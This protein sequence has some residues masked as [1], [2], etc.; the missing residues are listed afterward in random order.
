MCGVLLLRITLMIIVAWSLLLP[1]YLRDANVRGSAIAQTSEEDQPSLDEEHVE[2][3]GGQALT[4]SPE[5]LPTTNETTTGPTT[6]GPTT[7]GPTT[8]GPTTTGPTTTGPTTTG[9]TNETTNEPII[10]KPLITNNSALEGKGEYQDALAYYDRALAMDP[11]NVSAL[12]GKGA[13]L[14]NLGEYQDALAYYDRALAMD[15]SNVN[16]TS[17]KG[18]ALGNLGRYEEAIGYIDRALAMDPS[19]VNTINNKGAALFYLGREEEAIVNFDRVLA[20]DPSNVDALTNKG[21]TLAGLGRY[22][23]AIG[24]FDMVLNINPNYIPALVNTG[25][26]FGNLGRHQEAMYYFERASLIQE[27]SISSAPASSNKNNDFVLITNIWE[28]EHFSSNGLMQ[29]Y[30]NLDLGNLQLDNLNGD[31]ETYGLHFIS[32]GYEIDVNKQTNSGIAKVNIGDY[33]GALVIFDEILRL[34]NMHQSELVHNPELAA[35]LYNAGLCLEKLGN[36][37]GADYY[38]SE[39]F[40]V[41][42]SLD[43]DYE[44]GYVLKAHFSPPVLDLI[45]VIPFPRF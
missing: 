44:G 40:Q 12:E 4:V 2:N 16:I 13:A 7:T 30:S 35:N 31:K 29:Y 28:N 18:G 38:K 45:K 11:S 14:D 3:E 10:D 24:Y 5:P 21:T 1:I 19:N 20:M 17:N 33:Q 41:N 36:I 6:T 34:Y 43:P 39:A 26:A 9:P 32:H 22:E 27:S 25:A 23:E 42:A 37:S 15:P 8:T